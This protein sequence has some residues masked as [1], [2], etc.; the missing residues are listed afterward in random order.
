MWEVDYLVVPPIS[1]DGTVANDRCISVL[2]DLQS[3]GLALH[4]V[5]SETLRW[6]RIQR[7]MI[8]LLIMSTKQSNQASPHCIIV[9]RSVRRVASD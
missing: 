1:P 5:T 3:V 6:M 4:S 9:G 8:G 2:M 7:S